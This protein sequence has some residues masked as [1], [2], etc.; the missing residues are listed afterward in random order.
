ML[1]STS[2]KSLALIGH[3]RIQMIYCQLPNVQVTRRTVPPF[4]TT[5][6]PRFLEHQPVVCLRR[7]LCWGLMEF[8][9][10]EN[11][12]SYPPALPIPNNAMGTMNSLPT[13]PGSASAL[14]PPGNAINVES[15]MASGNIPRGGMVMPPI[16]GM[17]M[18]QPSFLD[19]HSIP[20]FQQLV[21]SHFI[22]R[23]SPY[24]LQLFN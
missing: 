9:W 4:K 19:D 20:A 7:L 23:T 10:Q 2:N 1:V 11:N 8:P 14:T 21:S 17:N 22:L 5:R 15:S 13:L 3:P 18:N 12:T 24:E 6:H 16:G